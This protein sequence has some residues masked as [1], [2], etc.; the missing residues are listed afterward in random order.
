MPHDKGAAIE[1]TCPSCRQ[2]SAYI[3]KNGVSICCSRLNQCGTKVPLLTFLNGGQKPTDERFIEIVRK[4]ADSIGL[5]LPEKLT[6]EEAVAAAK[7]SAEKSQRLE[8][9]LS[10]SHD[11]VPANLHDYLRGRGMKETDAD[12]GYVLTDNLALVMSGHDPEDPNQPWK[13]WTGR[14]A[15]AIRNR[16]GRLIG[17][18]A[19]SLDGSD[20]KYLHSKGVDFKKLGAMGLDR[21]LANG[22]TTVVL[23]EA[24]IDVYIARS[25]GHNEFIAIGGATLNPERLQKLYSDG[26]RK[27]FSLY[28]N[29]KAGRDGVDRLVNSYVAPKMPEV[30][31]PDLG[32]VFGGGKDLGEVTEAGHHV[33]TVVARLSEAMHAYRYKA[34]SLAALYDLKQD[35]GRNQFIRAAYAFDSTITDPAREDELDAYFWTEV[36]RL[37]NRDMEYVLNIRDDIKKAERFEDRQRNLSE[38]LRRSQEA[39]VSG[40]LS[41][42]MNHL[43]QAYRSACESV[44]DVPYVPIVSLADR[45]AENTQRLAER[46]GKKYL[47]LTQKTIGELDEATLGLRKMITVA[48]GPGVGKTIFIS[49]LMQDILTHHEDTCAVFVSWELTGDEIIDRMKSRALNAKWYQLQLHSTADQRERADAALA[50]IADRMVIIE[51]ANCAERELTA[52]KIIREVDALKRS[53]GCKHCVVCVDYVQ[54]MPVPDEIQAC[55]E[56]AIDKFLVN[57]MKK[58]RYHLGDD[59]LIVVSEVTKMGGYAGKGLDKAKGGRIIYASDAA[60]FLNP[61]SDDELVKHVQLHNGVVMPVG[62][63]GVPPK[64]EKGELPKVVAEIREALTE[65]GKDYV[66]LSI[67]KIRDGGKRKSFILTNYYELS[68]M[69]PGIQ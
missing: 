21:A 41:G 32:T 14:L 7:A 30:Y 31:V 2:R 67:A 49:Q 37:T 50:S 26:V 9:A 28:D 60:F 4:L 36:C 18:S 65:E 6:S 23:V 63:F 11:A 19:R 46:A 44:T 52:Q 29:D 43:G 61:L 40:D 62:R 42:A 69:E 25:H 13:A 58:I 35:E 56:L 8:A 33:N 64:I 24:L 68:R 53:T 5:T 1:L 22:N 10:I 27:V 15:L 48:A 38:N 59:P 45:L 17:F 66:E 3:Y 47:G 54:I 51:A 39:F 20:P 57:E 55:G 12:V 16:S 34:Q